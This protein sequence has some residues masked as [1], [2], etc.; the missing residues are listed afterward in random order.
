[1]EKAIKLAISTA[2]PDA[3]ILVA[4]KGHEPYQEVKG[5]KHHLDD[6]EICMD[7]LKTRAKTQSVKENA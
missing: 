7:A 5:V 2:S 6:R 1:R 4:G 3:M